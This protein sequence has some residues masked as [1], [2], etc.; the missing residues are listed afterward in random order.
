[1]PCAT[2]VKHSGSIKS[3][4][5]LVPNRDGGRNPSVEA[6]RCGVRGKPFF[7][8]IVLE[9][10]YEREPEADAAAADG[11]ASGEPA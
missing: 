2:I 3:R 1:M 4:S 9:D 11:G 5:S 7:E 8:G 6:F 10:S